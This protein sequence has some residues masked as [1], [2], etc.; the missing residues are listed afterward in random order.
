MACSLPF[1]PWLSPDLRVFSSQNRLGTSLNC[2][3]GLSSPALQRHLSVF[4]GRSPPPY[5]RP[6]PTL[7]RLREAPRL[8]FPALQHVR[9]PWPFFALHRLMQRPAGFASPTGSPVPRVWLPSRRRQLTEPSEASFSSQRSW[10]SPSRAFLLLGDQQRVSPPP[11]APAL[12]C[13]TY[14]ASHRRSSGFLPPKKPCPSSPP[15]RLIRTRAS[16]LL[17]FPPL[18]SSLR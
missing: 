6:R 18:R 2:S 13:E 12:P 7:S 8:S 15:G 17:G 9:I 11:S 1:R 5:Q 16:A 3:P 14:S 4:P 10:A